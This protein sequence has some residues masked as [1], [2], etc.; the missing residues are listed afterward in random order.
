MRSKTLTN[1]V[2]Y[3]LLSTA[4]IIAFTLPQGLGPQSS[5]AATTPA[6]ATYTLNGVIRDFKTTQPDFGGSISSGNGHYAGLVQSTLNASG[7]PAFSGFTAGPVEDFKLVNGTLVGNQPFYPMVTVIGAAISSGSGASQYNCPVTVNVHIG[8][9]TLAP[10]GSFD[11]PITGNVN[12]KTGNPRRYVHTSQL[13]AGTAISIEGRSWLKKNSTS[14]S[15]KDK[16]FDPYLTFAAPT[17]SSQAKVLRNGDTVPT[18]QG[19]SGQAS[20]KTFV[21]AF[22]DPTGKKVVLK[23][24]Q[25]IF[26][27]E[28]GTTDMSSSAAD[29]QDLVVLITLGDSSSF[30]NA[31]DPLGQGAPPANVPAGYKVASE[32]K[33]KAGN[34][35]PAQ[36]FN[37][38]ATGDVAGSKGAASTGGITSSATFD[39]W[40][41][42]QMGSNL[43][44]RKA[45]ILTQ[46]SSG[47]WEYLN[48][49]FF[50]IDQQLLGNQNAN[51]NYFFTY[52]FTVTFTHHA[53]QHRFIEFKGADD[54]WVFIDGKLAM[55]LGGLMANTQQYVD[56]DRLGLTDG[57]P[58]TMQFFYAQR[59]T[60]TSIFRLRTTLDLVQQTT[61]VAVT[62][63][64]D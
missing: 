56:V 22:L 64:G 54:A 46:N 17:N 53:G 36:L 18:V 38:G 12:T 19:V 26:F 63:A 7:R 9:S 47:V 13:P 30:L 6:G 43:S 58:H 42:D 24:N 21:Q 15:W 62:A 51:H 44:A 14:K 16:D 28:L 40:F 52:S 49:Q 39:Q 34:N 2:A 57:Q 32:W 45:I 11:L 31:L 3:G 35:I 55:D 4:G 41:A 48:D 33:D 5:R 61:S 20:L 10:F 29:M 50:P 1:V 60:S 8:N 59:N 27:F 23:A 37:V 25:A